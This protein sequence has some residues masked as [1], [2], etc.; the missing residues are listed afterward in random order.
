MARGRAGGRLRRPHEQR[1][2]VPSPSARKPDL[3]W[4][5]NGPFHALV[6]REE[7]LSVTAFD[8]GAELETPREALAAKYWAIVAAV[9]GL[10]DELP[11]WRLIKQKRAAF[12]ATPEQNA[13]RPEPETGWENLVLAGGYVRSGHAESMESAARSAERAAEIVAGR[14]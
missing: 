8:A 3:A 11:A 1:P 13:L 9:A 10:S 14:L 4:I 6:S 7:S 12:A 2:L 5:V